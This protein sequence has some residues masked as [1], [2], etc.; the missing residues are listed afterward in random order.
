MTVRARSTVD[1]PGAVGQWGV[2]LLFSR[3]GP[4][5]SEGTCRNAGANR[6]QLLDRR[7]LIGKPETQA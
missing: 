4:S 6:N 2:D 7:T 5:M 3:L 1:Q